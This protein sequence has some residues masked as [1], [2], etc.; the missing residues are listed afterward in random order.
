MG[1]LK[2]FIRAVD[3]LNEAIG[4]TASWLVLGAVIVCFL[5]AI[6]RYAFSIGFT[7][8]QELYVWQHALVFMLGAGYTMLHGG[9]VGV[10]ILTSRFT[11]RTRA[12]LDI[13][14]T[15]VFLFPWLAVIAFYSAPYIRASWSVRETS[16]S[17]DGMPGLFLLKSVIWV[18]CAILFLQGLALIARR[19]L[20]LKGFTF[21]PDPV[22][23]N[24][25][26]AA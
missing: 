19:V 6:L 24:P 5:V 2:S 4:R 23:Q 13:V 22:E 21:D 1:M 11:E 16:S 26:T 10:D 17:A 20:Y 12:W 7:W 15:F 3:A 14:S 25:P 9:H 8:M 18:F